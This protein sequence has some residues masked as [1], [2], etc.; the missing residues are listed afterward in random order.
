MNH[1]EKRN[2]EIS[3]AFVIFAAILSFFINMFSSSVFYLYTEGF[4]P[5]VLGSFIIF[6]LGTMFFIGL[7]SYIFENIENTIKEDS[8]NKLIIMYLKSWKIVRWF[9]KS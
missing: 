2:I 8:L 1:K 6:L 9:Y 7:L 4:N 5:N 3:W